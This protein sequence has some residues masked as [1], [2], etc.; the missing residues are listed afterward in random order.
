MTGEA[1][2][3]WTVMWKEWHEFLAGGGSRWRGGLG[4]VVVLFVFSIFLPIQT[5][6]SWTTS[7][8]PILIDA[9]YLPLSII[10][11][12]MADAFAGE[13]ERHTLETLLASRLSDRAILFGKIGAAI[14]FGWVLA[15]LGSLIGLVAVNITHPSGGIVFYSPG[16]TVGIVVFGLLA[17]TL[18]A[19]A[20][21]LVSLRAG[22]V[23]QAQ[24]MLGYG[25]M[26]LFFVPVLGFQ[27]I[28]PA[29]RLQVL[30]QISTT[31]GTEIALIALAVLLVLDATLLGIAIARFQRQ[32]LILD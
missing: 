32:R 4:I 20:G 30:Q 15:I 25:I 10:I 28:P 1:T 29:K 14:V 6:R 9:A 24:Q 19:G 26:V 5:G 17:S 12:M 11:N 21:G 31:S 8:L 3:I 22:T 27:L 7:A 2:D 13:R 18:A 23:R 16:T